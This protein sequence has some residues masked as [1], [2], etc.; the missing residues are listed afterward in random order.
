MCWSPQLHH[1]STPLSHWNIEVI[2]KH[3]KDIL[4]QSR[5]TST[6]DLMLP[7]STGI[8]MVSRLLPKWKPLAWSC[9]KTRLARKLN[10]KA[11]ITF[12]AMSQIL[13]HYISSGKHG[14]IWNMM[15]PLE[16]F[17]D[18][19]RSQWKCRERITQLQPFVGKQIVR[20]ALAILPPRHPDEL[21]NAL[22][23]EREGNNCLRTH[24]TVLLFNLNVLMSW[25]H[26]ALGCILSPR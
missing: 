2:S 9:W 4:N 1:Q 26:A 7:A 11:S 5:S 17:L 6:T 25:R 24:K 22:E 15:T 3:P 18:L 10:T 14:F 21:E 20:A 13:W 19:C 8:Q 23:L 16:S 12:P